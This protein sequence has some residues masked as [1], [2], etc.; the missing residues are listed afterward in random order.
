MPT[1][2]FR[3]RRGVKVAV[4]SN[5]APC[6]PAGIMTLT[7]RPG[8]SR[9]GPCR[10]S[11]GRSHG[12]DADPHVDVRGNR[13]GRG[14]RIPAPDLGA[15]AGPAIPIPMPEP[16]KLP[17]W[18]AP[19]AGRTCRTAL[20]APGE[21]PPRVARA[22]AVDDDRGQAGVGTEEPKTAGMTP[23]RLMPGWSAVIAAPHPACPGPRRPWP[24][25]TTCASPP[26]GHA[27]GVAEALG[28]PRLPGPPHQGAT[29]LACPARLRRG[30]PH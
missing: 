4:T 15:G 26:T 21:V 28:A 13:T 27:I 9:C 23:M 2:R 7:P 30:G 14:R 10:R 18:V 11:S 3:R 24:S 12:R 29:A 6:V 25:P 1:C 20:S 22:L 8:G 16:P 17:I 5:G 19:K